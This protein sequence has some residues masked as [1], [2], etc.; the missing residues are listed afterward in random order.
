MAV[1]PMLLGIP[2]LLPLLNPS[3][4]YCSHASEYSLPSP[5]IWLLLICFWVS[6]NG[7]PFPTLPHGYCSHASMN[8]QCCWLFH[9]GWSSPTLPYGC[10]SHASGYSTMADPQWLALPNPSTWLL[11]PCFHELSML[12][13]IPLWLVLP[14]P[15]ILLLFPCFQGFP[16]QLGIPL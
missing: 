16:I 11:F 5:F 15:S 3:H 4:G 12:L 10:C 6:N 9:S 7:W 2:L 1:A 14:N 13:A 8:S